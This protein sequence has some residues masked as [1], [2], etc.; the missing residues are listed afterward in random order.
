M[1]GIHADGKLSMMDP[2]EGKDGSGYCIFTEQFGRS[3][4]VIDIADQ[5]SQKFKHLEVPVPPMEDLAF[6]ISHQ[7]SGACLDDCCK[8]IEKVEKD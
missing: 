2:S 3:S 4:I 5:F 8:L 6:I 7:N 1:S